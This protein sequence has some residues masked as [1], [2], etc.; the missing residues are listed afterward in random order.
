[1]AAIHAKGMYVVLDNTMSTYV[2]DTP[3][4]VLRLLITSEAW[5]IS[6]D[7]KAI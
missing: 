5:E 2:V 7:S 4:F 1:M 6:L 3:S